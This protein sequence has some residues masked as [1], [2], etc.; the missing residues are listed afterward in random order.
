M[1]NYYVNG[2]AQ[3]NGDHEVHKDG[4]TYFPANGIYL[5]AFTE[6]Y[7]AVLQAQRYFRQVNGCYF[8]C[9]AC[10]TG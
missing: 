1:N 5:G 10:H 4:C 8:C 9:R 3:S 2:N 7:S 6:C